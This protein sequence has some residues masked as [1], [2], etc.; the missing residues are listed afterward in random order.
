MQLLPWVP[1][2][3]HR[4]VIDIEADA[5]V[6]VYMELIADVDEITVNALAGLTGGEVVT[7]SPKAAEPP[8][9]RKA[10]DTSSKTDRLK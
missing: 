9:T 10:P 5:L 8:P 4:V 7:I 3:C 2:N 1:D 6:K